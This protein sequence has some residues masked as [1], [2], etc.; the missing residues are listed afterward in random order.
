[1]YIQY[2]LSKC[3]KQILKNRYEDISGLAI[4]NKGFRKN[5]IN[6]EV[7]SSALESVADF[8]CSITF[9]DKKIIESSK[10]S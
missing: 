6:P 8:P 7:F 9:L 3:Q 4:T 5:S 2:L 1:M 10:V